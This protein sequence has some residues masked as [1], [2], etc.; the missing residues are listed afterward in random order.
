MQLAMGVFPYPRAGGVLVAVLSQLTGRHT[1][2]IPIPTPRIYTTSGLHLPSLIQLS[3]GPTPISNPWEVLIQ[4][5][6][7]KVFC[8]VL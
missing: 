1:L 4:S 2:E 6:A 7:S 5:K 3:L 8:I